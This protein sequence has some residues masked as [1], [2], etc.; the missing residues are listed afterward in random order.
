MHLHVDIDDIDPLERHRIDAR[1]HHHS[2]ATAG[3][4]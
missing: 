2:F 1:D 4:V 3:R